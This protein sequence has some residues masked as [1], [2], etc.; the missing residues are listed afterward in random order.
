MSLI[1]YLFLMQGVYC[2]MGIVK[3]K[4][5]WKFIMAYLF[6]LF[7]LLLSAIPLLQI[8]QLQQPILQAQV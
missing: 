1:A 8:L 7:I 5:L 2:I 3:A 4:A 6:R